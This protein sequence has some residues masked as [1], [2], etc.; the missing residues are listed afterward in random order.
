MNAHADQTI[1]VELQQIVPPPSLQDQEG[2]ISQC[3]CT[4]E[5]TAEGPEP[6]GS[7]SLQ[8]LHSLEYFLRPHMVCHAAE[9]GN[10]Q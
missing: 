2:L 3:N 9:A 7:R 6:K 10:W 5:V 4:E 1:E 8:T